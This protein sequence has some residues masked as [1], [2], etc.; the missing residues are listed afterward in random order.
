MRWLGM[1]HFADAV[2]ECPVISVSEKPS[3]LQPCA[4]WSEQV[5]TDQI[6]SVYFGLGVALVHLEQWT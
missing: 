5:P 1:L 4:P 3:W 6:H 2:Y